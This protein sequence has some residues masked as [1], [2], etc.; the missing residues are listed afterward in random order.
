MQ[1]ISNEVPIQ[2][3]QPGSWLARA[4]LS[5]N[6][7]KNSLRI[8]PS[9][10]LLTAIVLMNCRGQSSFRMF[11]LLTLDSLIIVGSWLIV[12]FDA[13]SIRSRHYHR[14]EHVYLPRN[15]E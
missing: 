9:G 13:V 11:P 14:I 2:N 4:L 15:F 3:R 6:D 7:S 1:L 5:H 12:M 10:R 8:A